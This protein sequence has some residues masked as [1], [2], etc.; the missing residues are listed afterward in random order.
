MDIWTGPILAAKG[1][2]ETP[3]LELDETVYEFGSAFEV[4]VET[5]CPEYVETL[6]IDLL[7]ESGCT[8]GISNSLKSKYTNYLAGNIDGKAAIA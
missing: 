4:E 2:N 1:V 8:E 3:I 5:S 6:L 7:R